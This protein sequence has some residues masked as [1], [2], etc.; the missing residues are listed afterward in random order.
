MGNKF[1]G[2]IALDRPQWKPLIKCHSERNPRGGNAKNLWSEQSHQYEVL[3]DP[4]QSLAPRGFAQDDKKGI[5]QRI[6]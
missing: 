3:K 4:E 5:N 1:V 6:Q 2:T